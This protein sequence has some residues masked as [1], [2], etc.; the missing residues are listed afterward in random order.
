MPRVR[1]MNAAAHPGPGEQ[2]VGGVLSEPPLKH[3]DH[4][5]DAS[6][7]ALCSPRWAVPAPPTPGSSCICGGPLP[8]LLRSATLPQ[9][10]L[11]EGLIV[12]V[13]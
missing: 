6:H 2:P 7:Y 11:G 13:R 10:T 12:M 1:G 4:A 5:L 9:R 8:A 3:D